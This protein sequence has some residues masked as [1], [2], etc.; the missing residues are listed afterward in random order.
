MIEKLKEYW[1]LNKQLER[2]GGDLHDPIY[3][4]Y[5]K[6]HQDF[7]DG[8]LKDEGDFK[9]YTVDQEGVELEFDVSYCGCCS[10]ESESAYVPIEFFGDYD[11]AKEKKLIALR[12]IKIAKAEKAKEAKAKKLEEAERAKV[13]YEASLKRDELETLARLT[14]KYKGKTQ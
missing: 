10:N 8:R 11:E 14:A 7:L 13:V 6:Y 1:E 9:E 3:E 4:V 12:L 5:A 2:L